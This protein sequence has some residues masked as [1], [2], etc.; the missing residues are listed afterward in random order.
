[1][2]TN[3]NNTPERVHLAL[4]QQ[5][6]RLPAAGAAWLHPAVRE[7]AGRAG[8]PWISVIFDTVPRGN[9][10]SCMEKRW[11]EESSSTC[12]PSPRAADPCPAPRR[13]R[14]ASRPAATRSRFTAT[15]PSPG[16]TRGP[17]LAPCSPSSS[18]STT[19]GEGG[20]MERKSTW[21]LRRK[22][23][24][25]FSIKK[26]EWG[27]ILWTGPLIFL[28]TLLILR[29]TTTTDHWVLKKPWFIFCV[30][31]ENIFSLWN[32]RHYFVWCSVQN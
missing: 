18:H 27:T 16:Q 14:G 4:P 11:D 23:C 25:T 9:R 1:M 22:I 30:S 29:R 5:V 20:S 26:G 24:R 28:W 13:G 10:W 32:H 8:D 15:T 19:S 6:P 7:C 31:K 3:E 2:S 17:S 21:A 12:P